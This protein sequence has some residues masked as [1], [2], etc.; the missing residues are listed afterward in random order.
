MGG[1]GVAAAVEAFGP[2]VGVISGALMVSAYLL[3]ITIS[4]VSAL[5][6][7]RGAAPLAARDPDPVAG[8][9]LAMG[10]LH[11]I[12]IRELGGWRWCWGWR[13]CWSKGRWSPR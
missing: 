1:G 5:Q 6:L 3:T 9:D 7:H 8:R 2:R 13:R 12:G 4:V 11:W 10:A